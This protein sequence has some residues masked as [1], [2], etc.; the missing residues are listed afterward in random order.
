MKTFAETLK[1]DRERLHMTQEQLAERLGV[2]QQAI[3]RWEAGESF[4]RPQRRKLL[5]EVLGAQSQMAQSPPATAFL[6]AAEFPPG[7]V[8]VTTAMQIKAAE[9]NAIYAVLRE[10]LPSDRVRGSLSFGTVKRYYDYVSGNAVANIVRIAPN[11]QL[12]PN[13]IAVPILR[14]A[15]AVGPEDGAPRRP[16]VLFIVTE[17]S[18]SAVRTTLE[19]V[20][21]DASA[22][23]VQVEIVSSLEAVAPLIEEIEALYAKRSQEYAEWVA[24]AFQDSQKDDKNQA[25]ST[26]PPPNFL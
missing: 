20:L 21:F 16:V 24:E 14:L 9:R 23:S 8:T 13:L 4:P 26:P 10:T 1:S 7:Q 25:V 19:A 18:A 2:S 5:L 22:L 3:A 11:V 6:P 17:Q 15:M 12:S